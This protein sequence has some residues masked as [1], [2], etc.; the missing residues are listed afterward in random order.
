L[1]P[2][3]LSRLGPL[4]RAVAERLL[5][6]RISLDL[7]NDEIV[8]SGTSLSVAGHNVRLT[9]T[10]ARLLG[11]L[12]AHPNTVFTKEHLLRTVWGN[13]GGDVHAVEVGVARLRRWLGPYGSSIRAV[14]RRGYTMRK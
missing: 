13:G 3:A 6:H 14:H 11:T 4:V 10:E 1:V 12:A 9:D 8:L 7:G 2:P 5:R